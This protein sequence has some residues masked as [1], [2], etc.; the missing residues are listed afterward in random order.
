VGIDP[1]SDEALVDLPPDDAAWGH[2]VC[3]DHQGYRVHYVRRGSGPPVVLLHGWPGF[4]YDY[5]RVLPRLAEVADVVA[6]DLRGFGSSER[7]ALPPDP[8]YGRDAQAAVVVAMLERLALPPV[9]LVGYDVGSGVAQAVARASPERVRALVLG[10][11]LHP[12]S[13]AM[14][15][16]PEHQHEFWYQDFHRLPLAGLLAGRDRASVHTYLRHF[17]DH[18]CA[19]PETVRAAEFEAIVDVYAA[20][21]ALDASMNWYRAGAATLETARRAARVRDPGP[22]PLAQ[23]ALVLW[24][25][26]D[27]LFPPAWAEGL[28]RSLADHRLRVL[29]GVGHFIPLEAPGAVIEAVAELS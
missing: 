26:R 16:L 14:A 17:Y 21:G 4:W 6:P 1:L 24:G 27:P 25:E 23:P 5:R 11:P 9:V 10:A 8:G 19:R 2:G 7:P 22:P 12:G 15:L 20:P 28:E 29:P 3:T 18:W 13:G